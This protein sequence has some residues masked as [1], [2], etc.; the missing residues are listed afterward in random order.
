MQI[1][2]IEERGEASS[3]LLNKALH[4]PFPLSDDHQTVVK[5]LKKQC[6][7]ANGVG[8]AAP[9]LDQ[10]LSIA[11]IYI[12]EDAASVRKEATP[13]PLH[14]MFNASFEPIEEQGMSEDFEACFSVG[15]LH[16]KVW[17]YNSIMVSYQDEDGRKYNH[18]AKGF[19]ARVLQHEIDHLNGILF[20]DRL[21]ENSITGSPMEMLHLRRSELPEDKRI[22]FDQLLAKKGIILED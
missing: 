8:L 19:Y 22:I 5:E 13:S 18:S 4:V 17:R 2:T 1:I 15:E 16:A 10:P 14:V 7:E 12:P 9:Q 6:Y 3:P 11:A 21:D 20:T